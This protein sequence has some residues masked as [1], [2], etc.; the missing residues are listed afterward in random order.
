MVRRLTPY[1]RKAGIRIMTETALR[2]IGAAPEG[3][4]VLTVEGPRG[5]RC[6]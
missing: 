4:L 5:K 6:V 1:L 2:E 3:G